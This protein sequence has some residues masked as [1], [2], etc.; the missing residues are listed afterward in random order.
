MSKHVTRGKQQGLTF[1]QAVRL[2]YLL[3]LP[4]Q[5][6]S[7]STQ[8]WPLVLFL[9]GKGERGDDLELVKV[10][11]LAKVVEQRPDFPFVV[12]SPQCPDGTLW[13]RQYAS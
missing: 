1:E 5:V 13:T 9:H 7:S 2:R 12:V 8:R 11:G 4:K 10:H 3:F 6:G